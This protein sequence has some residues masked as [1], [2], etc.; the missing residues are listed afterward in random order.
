[1][2]PELLHLLVLL[3][4]RRS[5]QAAAADKPQGPATPG[6]EQALPVLRCTVADAD[7]LNSPWERK[8]E[9]WRKAVTAAL[10]PLHKVGGSRRAGGLARRQRAAFS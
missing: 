7:A 9:A 4:V 2:E 1:M 6:G 8:P 10:R 3:D 5:S